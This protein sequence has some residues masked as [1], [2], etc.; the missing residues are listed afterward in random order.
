MQT[1]LTGNL[2]LSPAKGKTEALQRHQ[3]QSL[4]RCADVEGLFAQALGQEGKNAET[5]KP[6]QRCPTPTLRACF[7]LLLCAK[8]AQ[9]RSPGDP[10]SSHYSCSR[11]LEPKAAAVQLFIFPAPS[12]TISAKN[13]PIVCFFPLAAISKPF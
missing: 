6:Q 13:R 12:K 4:W 11:S 7:S 1:T 10:S 2:G 3:A 5:V 9:L 8:S